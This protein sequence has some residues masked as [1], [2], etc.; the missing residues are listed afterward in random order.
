M[1]GKVVAMEDVID[2]LAE[3]VEDLFAG[4]YEGKDAECTACGHW[5][6]VHSAGL[7]IHDRCLH[8]GCECKQAVLT[9]NAQRKTNRGLL[10]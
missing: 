3:P 10:P 5:L 4:I 9:P 1:F 6:T 8:P 7:I 2:L